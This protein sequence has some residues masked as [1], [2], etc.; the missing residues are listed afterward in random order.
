MG[1]Y[2][3]KPIIEKEKEEGSG[4][5]LSYACTTMQGWRVNQEVWILKMLNIF[6]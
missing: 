3:N 4:N 1:A 6:I 5:G 2:L